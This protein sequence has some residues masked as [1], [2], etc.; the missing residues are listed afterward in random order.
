[1]FRGF[2]VASIAIIVS[3]FLGGVVVIGMEKICSVLA[4][5][6]WGIAVIWFGGLIWYLRQRID[7][8]I[9]ERRLGSGGDILISGFIKARHKDALANL[10]LWLIGHG[11]SPLFSISPLPEILDS[12]FQ[13]FVLRYSLPRQY[14]EMDETN[15]PH[16]IGKATIRVV[17]S[18]S[19]WRSNPIEIPSRESELVHLKKETKQKGKT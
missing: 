13:Q 12:H 9:V 19:I 2:S 18:N 8:R 5:V 11:F 14:V 10:Q 6:L 1:M 15:H 4:Y 7:L 17:L 3:L 16:L